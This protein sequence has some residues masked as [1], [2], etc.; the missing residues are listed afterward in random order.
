MMHA[1]SVN[2][3]SLTF[4]YSDVLDS[5]CCVYSRICPAATGLAYGLTIASLIRNC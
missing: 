4:Q 2:S 3:S 5:R 1:S